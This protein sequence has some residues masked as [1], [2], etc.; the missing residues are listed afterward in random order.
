M[1]ES[2]G[3]KK[4]IGVNDVLISEIN[5]LH[6]EI[7][8]LKRD[9]YWTQDRQDLQEKCKQLEIDIARSEEEIRVFRYHQVRLTQENESLKQQEE[10]LKSRIAELEGKQ[11][12]TDE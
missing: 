2:G 7:E 1:R 4:D 12:K 11:E 5:R 10:W 6:K 8:E 9:N 3:A